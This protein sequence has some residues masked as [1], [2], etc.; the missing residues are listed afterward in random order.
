LARVLN[1]FAVEEVLVLLQSNLSPQ[2]D[3]L[4]V[5]LHG[6]GSINGSF[7]GKAAVTVIEDN[8]DE[9]RENLLFRVV[10]RLRHQLQLG[11]LHM[12]ELLPVLK[13]EGTEVVAEDKSKR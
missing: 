12:E 2:T 7:D 9:A 13:R 10:R 6:H 8:F 5:N 1:V 11:Q 3:F 4:S